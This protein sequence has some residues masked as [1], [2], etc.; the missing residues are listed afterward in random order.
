[1][2]G[3]FIERAWKRNT[4]QAFDEVRALGASENW[5]LGPA[6]P[7]NDSGLRIRQ[8]NADFHSATYIIARTFRGSTPHAKVIGLIWRNDPEYLFEIMNYAE[9]PFSIEFI[10]RH[11]KILFW[12]A[13][14]LGFYSVMG[15]IAIRFAPQIT[16]VK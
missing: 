8:I 9:L 5:Q 15:K 1:M 7:I 11:E 6:N 2:I 13:K 14:K 10:K 3:G 4:K 16:L 12:I